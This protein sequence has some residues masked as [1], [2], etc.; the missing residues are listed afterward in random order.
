M[1]ATLADAKV[2]INMD[3]KSDILVIREGL[4]GA[5]DL[6]LFASKLGKDPLI[7]VGF[8]SFVAPNRSAICAIGFCS[9]AT[10]RRIV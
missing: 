5:S 6:L 1:G 3:C 4:T 10:L 9:L 7:L 2:R 8:Q